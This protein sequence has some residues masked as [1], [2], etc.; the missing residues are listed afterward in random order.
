MATSDSRMT[1]PMDKESH[2]QPI[3][4][5]I[6]A[7]NAER[8]I[9]ETLQSIAAQ[10]RLPDRVIIVDD[11][12]KDGTVD[13]V[14]AFARTSP[15]RLQLL[16]QANGGISKAR[17]RGIEEIHGGWVAFIDADDLWL[18]YSLAVLEEAARAVP[19][20]VAVFGDGVY[21]S[22]QGPDS[23][24]FSRAKALA[25]GEPLPVPGLSLLGKRLFN[26]VLPGNFI[27][28]S[29]FMVRTEALRAIGGFDPEIL[30]HEDRLLML[31]LAKAGDFVFVDRVVS[32]NRIHDNNITHPR[33]TTR[34][35][36]FLLR[37][38]NKLNTLMQLSPEEV[39]NIEAQRR[40]IAHQGAY[41]ASTTGLK[42]YL[43]FL[44]ETGNINGHIV[45][46]RP[47]DI[48]RAVLRSFYPERI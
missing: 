19:H 40:V 2:T 17:N 25:A 47:K 5:L 20:A 34:N 38:L 12:S 43:N 1:L 45:M 6:P 26:A 15:L 21:F 42:S 41:S 27:I 39:K 33:N 22:K 10:T 14:E 23:G 7:Y 11:G 9:D 44:R 31:R 29:S 48:A 8:F 3:T 4:V 28:P 32:R 30:Y 24:P 36:L 13:I 35:Q 37:I 16:R 18:P 46:P